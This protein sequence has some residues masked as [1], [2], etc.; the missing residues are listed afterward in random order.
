M[1]ISDGDK[2]LAGLFDVLG[3][4]QDSVT[5]KYHLYLWE[6]KPFPGPYNP[7]PDIVR[8][9]SKFHHAEGTDTLEETIE[10]IEALRKNITIEDANVWTTSE[11]VMTKDMSQGYAGVV[12]LP[13]WKKSSGLV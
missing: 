2:H 9:K 3:I 4:V 5:K 8:L 11:Q 7:N 1:I 13:N 12:V 6:E 10:R